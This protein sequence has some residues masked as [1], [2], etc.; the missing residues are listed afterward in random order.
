[1]THALQ[2]QTL[3]TCPN[4][5]LT[6]PLSKHL[7]SRALAQHRAMLAMEIEFLAKKFDR[8]GWDRERNTPAQDRQKLDFMDAL[9]DFP[10]SEVQAACKAAVLANPNRMPNEGHIVAEVLNARK[11]AVVFKP[12][13]VDTPRPEITPEDLERRAA[14]AAELLGNVKRMGEAQ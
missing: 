8:F 9:Q 4:T 3:P 11:R 6:L 13:Q 7:D 10:L 2:T 1:M 14:L 5:G 12:R